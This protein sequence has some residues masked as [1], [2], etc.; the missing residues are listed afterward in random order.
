MVLLPAPY[1][2]LATDLVHLGASTSTA[3]ALAQHA[4]SEGMPGD[5]A[6]AR[7]AQMLFGVSQGIIS[8][9]E[10]TTMLSEQP[11]YLRLEVG[12]A[13]EDEHLAI[14]VLPGTVLRQMQKI[15][16]CMNMHK[17]V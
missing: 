11:E 13:Y 10:A 9:H 12:C 17:N 1:S 15:R 7:V 8:R 4:L 2:G 6:R 3:H 14:T 16:K 5:G